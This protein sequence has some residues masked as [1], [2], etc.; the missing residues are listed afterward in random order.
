MVKV[1]EY[2]GLVKN[3]ESVGSRRWVLNHLIA[4]LRAEASEYASLEARVLM[5]HVLMCDSVAL[6]CEPDA[7][8]SLRAYEMLLAYAE[9]R[10]RGEPLAHILGER[11]FWSLSFEV[12][13]ATL[14]PRPDSETVVE[15]VLAHCRRLGDDRPYSVVDLGTGSGCLLISVLRELP[16][17]YGI[18]VDLSREAL[19][20]ALRNSRRH[21]VADRSY[22]CSGHW[23]TAL[24]GPFDIIIS[25]PPY[26]PT[27]DIASLDV[28]VRDYDPH[29][30]LDGGPDGLNAYRSIVSDVPNVLSEDGCVFLEVGINQMCAIEGLLPA[31]HL[32]KKD[33]YKDLEGKER[34]L[35]ISRTELN[36]GKNSA[37]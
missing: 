21:H 29:L 11:E 30:A 25:N 4:R 34:V 2:C 27:Q 32:K 37:Y 3:S 6:M 17:A 12:T 26:I 7:I 10:A 24:K 31:M 15:A 8:V 19:D 14:V 9:R 20:V 18:G 16:R 22:F 23:L 33:I 35:S 28:T 36:F 13:P 5:C 1:E